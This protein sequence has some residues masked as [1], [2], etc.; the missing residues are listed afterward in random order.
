[1]GKVQFLKSVSF[2]ILLLLNSSFLYSNTI[3]IS[4]KVSAANKPVKNAE[5]IITNQSDSLQSFSTLTDSLGNFELY[6]TITSVNTSKPGI[7]TTFVLEQ[8]YPNPFSAQTNIKYSLGEPSDISINIYDIL[9]QEVK[10]FTLG[11][12][13]PGIYEISWD[14]YG[15]PHLMDSF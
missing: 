7:P 11:T 15:V 6:I 5:I 14:G 1:V 12:H 3:K 4:G 10:R 8:N 9:G 13:V 2:I